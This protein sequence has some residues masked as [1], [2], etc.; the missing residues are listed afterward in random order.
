MSNIKL[1]KNSR[2]PRERYQLSGGWRIRTPNPD[3][4]GT[5]VFETGA[6]AVQPTLRRSE[7]SVEIPDELPFMIHFHLSTNAAGGIRT[8]T[9]TVLETAASAV[10][11]PRPFD[12]AQ[13]RPHQCSGQDSNLQQRDSRSRASA[14]IGLPEHSSHWTPEGVE[15]S[16]PGCRPGVL[17]LDDGPIDSLCSLRAGP[18]LPRCG[19]GSNLQPRPSE[20]RALI[21]LSYRNSYMVQA[22][23]EPARGCALPDSESGA[24]SRWAT[25]PFHR[26]MA[27]ALHCTGRESNPHFS[28]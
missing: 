17:P 5:P 18:K 14:E 19:K 16:F 7:S 27:R 11:L 22:G 15:P 12:C 4:S 24:W 26:F 13:G 9:Q 10:G 1:S 21:R 20:S 25:E 2:H 3:L 8:H 28:A 23:F 6:L